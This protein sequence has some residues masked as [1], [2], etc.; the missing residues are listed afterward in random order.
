[1]LLLWEVAWLIILR[2]DDHLLRH[3][4]KW[5]CAFIGKTEP[6]IRRFD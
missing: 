3:R 2:I 6:V 4:W 1:M 5:L